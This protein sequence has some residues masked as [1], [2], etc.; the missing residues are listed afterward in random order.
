MKRLYLTIL[1]SALSVNVTALCKTTAPDGSITFT[2]RCGEHS[3]RVRKHGGASL[4]KEQIAAEQRR[5]SDVLRRP[6]GATTPNLKV[7]YHAR[8]ALSR[9]KW[10]PGMTAED[11]D[12]LHRKGS[13]H[14]G[15]R[16]L[17]LEDGTTVEYRHYGRQYYRLENDRVTSGGYS[18]Y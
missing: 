17:S 8:K 10:T 9:G 11:L 2:D 4:T 7:K 15:S 3:E 18:D 5:Y 1:L 16:Y 6:F 14:S 12:L 13:G